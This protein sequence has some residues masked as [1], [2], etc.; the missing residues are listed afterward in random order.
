MWRDAMIKWM[1]LTHETVGSSATSVQPTR[2]HGATTVENYT[3]SIFSL[4]VGMLMACYGSEVP[5]VQNEICLVMGHSNHFNL[6]AS[7]MICTYKIHKAE[8]LMSVQTQFTIDSLCTNTI[9][10]TWNPS[11]SNAKSKDSLYFIPFPQT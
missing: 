11:F 9:N 1:T 2:S 5:V 8:L 7:L 6:P 10:R 4:F 3:C